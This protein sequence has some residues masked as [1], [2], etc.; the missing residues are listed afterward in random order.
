M[1]GT[2]TG[3]P[4]TLRCARCKVGR[5][6]RR[7]YDK[8]CH[9]EATGRVRQLL[10]SQRRVNV[11]CMAVQA[12][13]RCLDCGHVGW[14]KHGDMERLLLLKGFRVEISGKWPGVPK[15]RKIDV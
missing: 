5:D 6:F 15:V 8:G 1:A 3:Y 4:L 2:G 14:S 12:E 10:P 11:R 9:L 13:Y 7:D